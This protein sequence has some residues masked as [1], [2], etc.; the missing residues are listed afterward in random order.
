MADGLWTAR[1]ARA[2]QLLDLAAPPEKAGQWPVRL[3]PAYRKLLT[4]VEH[5]PLLPRVGVELFR[6]DWAE[7]SVEDVGAVVGA[8]G[9]ERRGFG[10]SVEVFVSAWSGTFTIGVLDAFLGQDHEPRY[11]Y[12]GAA[13]A[14]VMLSREGSPSVIANAVDG[15]VVLPGERTPASAFTAL[16]RELERDLPRLMAGAVTAAAH[17]TGGVLALPPARR[18]S[19]RRGSPRPRPRPAAPGRLRERARRDRH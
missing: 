17:T 1:D 2:R 3:A 6:P 18:Q 14:W 13:D 15:D 11:T 5:F 4:E 19:E 8:F 16:R 12:V 9:Q 10:D 7:L